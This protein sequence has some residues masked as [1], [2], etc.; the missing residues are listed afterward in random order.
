PPPR[1]SVPFRSRGFLQLPAGK[2]QNLPSFPPEL[3]QC[4][5]RSAAVKGQKGVVQD[6]RRRRGQQK[7]RERQ[8]KGEPHLVGGAAAKLLQG[9]LEP[10]QALARREYLAILEH[11]AVELPAGEGG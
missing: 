6:E 2:E 9:A 11:Q 10:A 5:R 1:Y 4:R 3:F 8:A 7:P